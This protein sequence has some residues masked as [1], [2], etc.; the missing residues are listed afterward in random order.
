[1]TCT[2]IYLLTPWPSYLLVSSL[3]LTDLLTTEEV[4]LANP[5]LDGPDLGTK[6]RIRACWDIG[7]VRTDGDLWK[8]WGPEVREAAA[9]AAD[10]DQF[11]AARM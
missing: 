6:R 8:W 7:G 9:A 2:G 4:V 11:A 10:T 5:L 3:H 1:M